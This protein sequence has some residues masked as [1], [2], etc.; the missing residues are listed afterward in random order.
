[1]LDRRDSEYQQQVAH[2]HWMLDQ[3]WRRGEIGDATYLRSL[4]ISGIM[5]DEARSRLALLKMEKPAER[6][7]KGREQ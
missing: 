1:M 5:P 7:G 4:F 6:Y 2:E 3:H